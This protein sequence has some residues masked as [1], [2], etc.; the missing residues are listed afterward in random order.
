MLRQCGVRPVGIQLVL[1]QLAL[2]NASLSPAF[3]NEFMPK[4]SIADVSAEECRGHKAIVLTP[5]RLS[6]CKQFTH[7]NAAAS[8]S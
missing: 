7:R 8:R 3:G 1:A 6:C 5:T 2:R 4:D